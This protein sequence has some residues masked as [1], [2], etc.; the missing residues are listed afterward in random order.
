[1]RIPW[2]WTGLLL[3]GA[4]GDPVSA[5]RVRQ[6]PA[7]EWGGEH[8][9]LSV[10]T[11]GGSIEFDCGHG[12]LDAPL[13]LDGQGRFDIK[14]VFVREGGP[15]R[16]GPEERQGARYSGTSDG[17]TLELTVEFASGERIG[18]FQLARGAA[19]RLRKC[20]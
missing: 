12:S 15:V 6:V 18:T 14:G 2:A 19:A 7:G 8:V 3:L 4:G 11:T 13:K 1:M 20:K 16:E 10:G 9:A 17:K 5:S